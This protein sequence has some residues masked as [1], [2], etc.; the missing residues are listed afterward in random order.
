MTILVKTHRLIK[1]NP[2]IKRR[3]QE[4]GSIAHSRLPGMYTFVER[5][6]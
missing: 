5:W 1:E 6:K 3:I 2:K 4:D